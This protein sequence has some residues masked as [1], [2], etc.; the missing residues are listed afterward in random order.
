MR[1]LLVSLVLLGLLIPAV[2]ADVCNECLKNPESCPSSCAQSLDELMVV[3]NLESSCGDGVCN[4]GESQSLCPQ[5]CVITHELPVQ[6]VKNPLVGIVGWSV[7][8]IIFIIGAV[9][10]FYQRKKAEEKW[11]E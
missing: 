1:T 5:D 11:S 6:I 10:F 4:V 8:A 3:S 7:G 9:L 2:Y